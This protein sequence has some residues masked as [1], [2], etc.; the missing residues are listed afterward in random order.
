[1]ASVDPTW[2]GANPTNILSVANGALAAGG[3]QPGA[4]VS[5]TIEV[6]V[7]AGAT[8]GSIVTN[9]AEIT[10]A[11]D[12]DGNP[13]ADVDSTPDSQND[14]VVGGDNVIDGSGNDEDDHDPENIVIIDETTEEFIDLVLIKSVNTPN[15]QIGDTV[16]FTCLLYTSP[17]PRD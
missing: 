14:D 7:E 8:A 15:A 16:I 3:L 6:V 17:S 13:M 1:M 2:I 4:S 11:T 12:P 9:T 5:I 10:S